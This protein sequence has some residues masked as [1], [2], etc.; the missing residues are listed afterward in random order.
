VNREKKPRSRERDNTSSAKPASANT[1]AIAMLAQMRPDIPLFRTSGLKVVFPRANGMITSASIAAVE[2][3]STS[4]M[5]AS[6]ASATRRF[7]RTAVRTSGSRF[8]PVV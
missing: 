4:R 2:T 7:R 3:V 8:M 1:A 5:A 6:W